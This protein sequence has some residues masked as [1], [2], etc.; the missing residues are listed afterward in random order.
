MCCGVGGRWCR[1]CWRGNQCSRAARPLARPG[2]GWWSSASGLA[3]PRQAA[4]L[5][6]LPRSDGMQCTVTVAGRGDKWRLLRIE[7]GHG[8]AGLNAA[9]IMAA[10]WSVYILARALLSFLSTRRR[11]APRALRPA[12]PVRTGPSARGNEPLPAPPRPLASIALADPSAPPPLSRA[13]F[14]ILLLVNIIFDGENGR[15]RWW[16]G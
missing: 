16:K 8:A 14:Y 3:R 6:L 9:A 2:T 13:L 11:L 10:R 5:L 15:S 4:P 7:C 12:P 1:W